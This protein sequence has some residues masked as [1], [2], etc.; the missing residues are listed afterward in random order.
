[1]IIGPISQQHFPHRTR[2]RQHG[3][4]GRDAVDVDICD[5]DALAKSI[6]RRRWKSFILFL[7][8][9]SR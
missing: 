3:I 1:V 2:E 6:H 8:Q 7:R 4:A 9:P 5:A